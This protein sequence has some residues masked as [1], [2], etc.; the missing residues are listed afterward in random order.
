MW[1][2]VN[3]SETRFLARWISRMGS[4]WLALLF[5]T[6]V[7]LVVAAFLLAWRDT[8]DEFVYVALP[9]LLAITA[10]NTLLAS[11][12]SSL[13]HV[14]RS[15]NVPAL[16]ASTR[17][18][19]SA[20]ARLGVRDAMYVVGGT[21]AL[22]AALLWVPRLG[23]FGSTVDETESGSWGFWVEASS[24]EGFRV[25]AQFPRD[26]QPSSWGI[27]EVGHTLLPWTLPLCA[28]LLV[29]ALSMSLA[30]TAM[31][32]YWH[33]TAGLNPWKR[34]LNTTVVWLG[35]FLAGLLLLF[36]V[37]LKAVQKAS[38]RYVQAPALAQK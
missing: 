22:I 31:G 14:G 17:V 15:R 29:G 21:L 8:L 16:G 2:T 28:L 7:Y 1:T 13:E 35:L 18:W 20:I 38:D 34:A 23:L 10:V 30:G 5:G 6:P 36:P 26:L 4:S 11:F 19:A 3:S 37:T 27:T 24:N 33:S 32:M 9:T 12:I 25:V